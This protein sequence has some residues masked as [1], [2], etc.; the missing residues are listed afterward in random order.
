MSVAVEIIDVGPRDGFQSI[1]PFIATDVKID[2]IR[3]LHAAGLRRIETTS[4]VNPTAIA[5]MA[6]AAEIVAAGAAIDGLEAQILVP[7]LRQMQRALE[8]GCLNFAA[9]A[10][11]SPAHNMANVRRTPMESVL[12]YGRMIDAMP[13]GGKMRLNVVTAFD[14]PF[15]GRVAPDDVRLIMDA[16]LA[17]ST[18]VEV[19]L[20][21][22]TGRAD[23]QQVQQLFSNVIAAYPEV[24]D[25]AFH[26]HDTY[27]MGTANVMAAYQACVRRFDASIAGLGGC[28]F[29]PGAT[30]NVATEDL[31]WMFD[32]MGVATGIDLEALLA[33]AQDAAALEGAQSGGRVRDAYAG[34]Q[35][36]EA[37][38]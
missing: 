16:L 32:H 36:R 26:G 13:R 23:P 29:A 5:Q 2:L 31:V 10:S 28:P 21:D 14:C 24:S 33:V 25:W 27:G 9:I 38:G 6:D 17:I 3:R 30:G 1:G 12:E 35:Q 34:R 18:D 19:A 7:S 20:C 8:V 11:V 15:D 37:R 22:T 4:F